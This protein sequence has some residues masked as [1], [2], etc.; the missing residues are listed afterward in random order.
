[1]DGSTFSGG[2]IWILLRSRRPSFDIRA[3]CSEEYDAEITPIYARTSP[4]NSRPLGPVAG[5]LSASEIGMPF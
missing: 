5:I 3:D 4:F 1:M 2:A